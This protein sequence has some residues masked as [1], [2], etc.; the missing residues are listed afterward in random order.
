MRILL[1]ALA[2]LAAGAAMAQDSTLQTIKQLPHC[3]SEAKN[4]F[5]VHKEYPAIDLGNGFVGFKTEDANAEG[6]KE[7]FSLINCATRAIVQLNAEYLLKDS[8]KGIPAS[9]DM[10]AFVDK[11]KKQGKL[12]NGDLFA[13]LASQAGYEVTNGKLPKVGDDKAA[14]A[15]CGCDDFYPE[16]RSLWK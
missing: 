8:S 9:G 12:A 11:L 10:F 13:G 15:E 6:L 16:A 1:T 5:G 4:S 7:R 3:G 14:R 2:I